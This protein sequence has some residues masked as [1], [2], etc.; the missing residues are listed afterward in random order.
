MSR[1]PL[2]RRRDSSAIARSCVLVAKPFGIRMRSM[3][4]PGVRTRA[5]T[6]SHF[7]RSLSVFFNASYP[8]AMSSGNSSRMV[9]A[10]PPFEAFAASIA[11][12]PVRIPAHQQSM[13]HPA[14]G[15]DPRIFAMFCDAAGSD[16]TLTS[17]RSILTTL[18]LLAGAWR[19]SG[20]SHRPHLCR[21][22]PVRQTNLSLRR[23]LHVER[24][25]GGRAQ[26]TIVRVRTNDVAARFGERSFHGSF[27]IRDLHVAFR[28]ED[29]RA[30]S[31]PHHPDD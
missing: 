6:P 17:R 2:P 30:G 23:R 19:A 29:R 12:V 20:V 1:M 5:N 14:G 10:S 25:V 18:M 16:Q 27:P 11:L 31:A 24:N 26:Q 7:S 21:C 13:R 8:R 9:S 15:R 4:R 28:I 22:G 3:K